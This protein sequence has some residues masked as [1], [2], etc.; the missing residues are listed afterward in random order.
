MLLSLIVCPAPL[1]FAAENQPVQVKADHVEYFDTLQKVVASGSVVAVYKDIK[2]T[3]DEATIY[4]ATKDAYLK[5]SVRIAQAGTLLKGEEIIYNFQTRKGVSLQAEVQADPFR[6]SGDRAHK[7]AD[8][9][10]TYRGGYLTTCDF[11][12]PHSRVQATEIKIFLDDKVVLKDAVIYLGNIPVFYMP[13]YVY[14]LDDKRPRVTII[15][16]NSKE[17]GAFLLSSWRLYLHENVQGRIFFDARERLGLAEGL[18]LKY[19]LP[20]GGTGIMRSYFTDQDRILQKH[21]LNRYTHREKGKSTVKLYRERFQVRHTAELDM[22]TKA[23]LEVHHRRDNAVVKDFFPTEFKA[24]PNPQTYFQ[25]VRATPW[26][27]LTFLMTKRVNTFEAITQNWPK[28]DLQIRPIALPWL[29]QLPTGRNRLD[30]GTT[31]ERSRGSSLSGSSWYYQS[32]FSYTHSNIASPTDVSG[33][34]VTGTTAQ[35]LF[36]VTKLF[37]WLNARPFGEFQEAILS[38]NAVATRVIPRQ[39]AATGVELSSRFFR[40]FPIESNLWRLDIH[41]IRHIINPLVQYRY[42]SE[43]TVR[44]KQLFNGGD[45]LTRSNT[46]IPSIEQKL[47]TKRLSGGKWEAVDVARLFAQTSYDFVGPKG[48]AGRWN[49][50][51]MDLETKPYSWLYA[52]SDGHID[53]HIGKFLTINADVLVTGG[54]YRSSSSSGK[55]VDRRS[56]Y[57]YNRTAEGFQNSPWAAGLGWRY[58]RKTSGQLAF[59]TEFDLDPKW[60]VGIYQVMDVKRFA[61]ESTT[62]GPKTTKKIYDVP[63]QSFRLRRD[64]HEWTVELLYNT[65]RGQGN[66]ILLLFRLKDFP[67]LPFDFTEHYKQPKAGKNYP[68]GSPPPLPDIPYR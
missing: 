35:Q 36:Y 47:Q 56:G 29:P 38:R 9:E 43:P 67:E 53:P 42:Q 16:G 10:F 2:L 32:N 31:K 26:Y 23:T 61:T 51:D 50:I 19:R 3:C 28:L 5:G 48:N 45:G 4:L 65:L 46:V 22:Q 14:P 8:S 64:L 57:A 52:E 17:W 62:L 49:N 60:R 58:Q 34:Y 63:D 25:V 24:D 21:R 18:E 44:A 39:S 7:V 13:S 15:P 30:T 12:T 66:A 68:K 40:V 55:T 1:L 33:S 6:A 11:E 59:E 41:N 20:V 37:G 54:G 27:G